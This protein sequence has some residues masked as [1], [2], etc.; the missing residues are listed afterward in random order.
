M[1][2]EFLKQVVFWGVWLFIPTMFDMCVGVYRA[3]K[4]VFLN[5]KESKSDKNKN[6][7]DYKDLVSI[8]IPVYNSE[9]CLEKC[10]ESVANQ[11]YGI[12]NIEIILVDNGSIDLSYGVFQDV[13][14]KNKNMVV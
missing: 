1:D 2:N 11:S 5:L 14:N 7:C 6:D 4:M 9:E 3:I 12:E 8:I 13:Q 10:I